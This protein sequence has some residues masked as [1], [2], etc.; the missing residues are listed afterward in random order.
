MT[1]Y[2]PDQQRKEVAEETLASW[3]KYLQYTGKLNLHVAD[4]GSNISLSWYPENVYQCGYPKARK[5][6]VTHSR[7][8]Q[9]GVGASLNAGFRQA[10]KL[11]PYVMYMVDDWALT[12]PFD[13]SPWVRLL[14]ERDDIGMVRLGPPHPGLTGRIEMFTDDWQ[15][16]GLRLDRHSFAF[17]HRPAIYYKRLIDYYGWFDENVSA[18]E[19]ERMYAE[20]WA[21]DKSGPDIVLALPH[22]FI[23]LESE[24][25]SSLEPS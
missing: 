25:L 15:G 16:W 2:F 12:E 17:G 7:Q 5:M 8:E 23:H 18:L 1:T 6:K 22:P 4:D 9:R 3:Q 24:S 20:R 21:A 14:Q 19:C 10:F 11:S 13:I